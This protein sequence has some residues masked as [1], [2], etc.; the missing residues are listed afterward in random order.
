MS[1]SRARSDL[2]AALTPACSLRSR[3]LSESSPSPSRFTV[4]SKLKPSP[5]V[6]GG[7]AADAPALDDEGEATPG[8]AIYAPPILTVVPPPP[9]A[10]EA[11]LLIACCIWLSLWS[12]ACMIWL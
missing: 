4:A 8:S 12:C 9:A 6:A 3:A 1:G 2:V 10:A 5:P 7:G 11:K